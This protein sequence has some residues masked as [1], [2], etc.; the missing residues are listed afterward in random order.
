MIIEWLIEKNV[1]I[2]C[3]ARDARQ[4]DYEADIDRG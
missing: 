1:V 3:A 4:A 2:F